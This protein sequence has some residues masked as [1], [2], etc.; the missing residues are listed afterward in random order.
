MPELLGMFGGWTNA[1]LFL[2]DA[3]SQL[4]HSVSRT[5]S[6]GSHKAKAVPTF[7]ERSGKVFHKSQH[8]STQNMKQ[9]EIYQIKEGLHELEV[10]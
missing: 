8:Y 2:Y 1:A 9:P 4:T 3:G 10:V 5:S 6:E 7:W